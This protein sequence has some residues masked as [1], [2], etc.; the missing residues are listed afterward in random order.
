MSRDHK[1][2]SK[3][4]SDPANSA[5]SPNAL[6][7]RAED[8]A[9]A[10]HHR[11]R[12]DDAA[13]N[14]VGAGEAGDRDG[15]T[16]EPKE[17]L[18]LALEHG[19]LRR[20][21]GQQL[22]RLVLQQ[23]NQSAGLLVGI[24]GAHGGWLPVTAQ[25]RNG[26]FRPALPP[27]AGGASILQVSDSDDPSAKDQ[28]DPMRPERWFAEPNVCGSCI[29]WTSREPAA[30]DDVA[31]GNCRLR[32][33][34][35]RVPATMRKCDLYKP[36]GKFVYKAAKAEPERKRR[37]KS[38]PVRVM[39]RDEVSGEMVTTQAPAPI[40][41]S[42]PRERPPVPRTVDLG[43]DDQFLLRTVMKEVL[44]GQYPDGGRPLHA[45]FEGGMVRIVAPDGGVKKIPVERFFRLL[46]NFRS[47]LEML[48][49]ELVSKDELL[50]QFVELQKVVRAIRGSLTSFN[51]LY[52]DR[53][54]YFSGKA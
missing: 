14:H 51:F 16:A 7:G 29:A 52:D 24:I 34:L 46:E 42:E 5:H 32:R 23:P 1:V 17:H 33:E 39:R 38:A 11:D 19:Q 10:D 9:D 3:V 48:E 18:G 4:L 2:I 13:S 44:Q 20:Q 8:E 15:E 31:V 43:T 12:R 36:R 6:G 41:S 45:R 25:L 37:K 49:D 54:D 47:S 28:P 27:E 40:R 22:K 50:D 30:D 26:K 35:P 21:E 53:R